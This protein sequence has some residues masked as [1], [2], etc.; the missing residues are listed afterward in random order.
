MRYT[1]MIAFV[2][3]LAVT[4]RADD[5][6]IEFD[7]TKGPGVGKHIVL[8]SGDE[9]YR[10][11]EALPQLAKILATHHG[12]R[13]TVLFAVDPASGTIQPNQ[14]E[15][16][17][18]LEKLADADL[19]IIA[20]R[21]RTPGDESMQAIENYLKRGGPVIGLRTATHAFQFPKNSKWARYGNGY[22][23]DDKAW[24]GGFGRA[25]VG[26][27][28]VSHHG[29]HKHEGTRGRFAPA[30]E[31]S[32]IL[33]GIADGEV[34]GSSDVYGVRLPMVDSVTP[35]LFGES[36]ARQGEFDASDLHYGMRPTDP[37]VEGDKN[38][39]K[40]PIAWTNSYRLEGGETGRVFAT[41]MGAS[42]DI[43]NAAVRRMIVNGVYW[44]LGLEDKIPAGGTAVDIVGVYNPTKFEFRNNDHWQDS[45]L[46][47]SDFE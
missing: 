27:Q 41:T 29:H 3:L 44:A 45:A 18:G 25:V 4:T 46:K 11:E 36:T 42:G 47:P 16:L 23:G 6:W 34:W 28:W 14:H 2:L 9:E 26:E 5:Q 37:P 31:D 7:G 19:M 35:L 13:C 10:S 20:T 33:R 17:P 22:S 40:M 32:P 8:V 39:V 30:A 43:A 21:F 24:T 1:L 12:F 15:H 38:D